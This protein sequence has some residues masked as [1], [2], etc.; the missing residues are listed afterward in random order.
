MKVRTVWD[1]EQEKLYFTRSA[2]FVIRQHLV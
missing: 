1:E 2:V